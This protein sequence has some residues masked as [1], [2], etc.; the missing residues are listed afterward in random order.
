MTMRSTTDGAAKAPRPFGTGPGTRHDGPPKV[1]ALTLEDLDRRTK[2]AQRAFELHDKLVAERGGVESMS[3]LRYAMT[4]STAVLSAMIEDMQARWLRGE[5]IDPA[6]IATL[7]NAR[8]REAEL[9]G[10]D[11]QPK[12]VTPALADYVAAAKPEN[13]GES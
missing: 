6:S 5:P 8:R 7:L 4:R 13:G 10:I 2:A 1:R 3:V 9:I 11:P 12:D